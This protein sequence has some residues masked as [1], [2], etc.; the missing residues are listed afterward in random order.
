MKALR[1]PHCKSIGV[2][3]LGKLLLSA[4][5]SVFLD[6]PC[7]HCGERV[8]LAARTTH[9]Q[10]VFF[11]ALFAVGGMIVPRADRIEYAWVG[12]LAILAVG[13]FSPLASRR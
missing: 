8:S 10:F 4:G 3:L 9:Y 5:A 7:R 1:C 2:S 11:V 13:L 12:G 6:L